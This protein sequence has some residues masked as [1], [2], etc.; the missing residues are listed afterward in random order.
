MAKSRLYERDFRFI[1]NTSNRWRTKIGYRQLKLNYIRYYTLLT[2]YSLF[3]A[4]VTCFT[5]QR[6]KSSLLNR[7]QPCLAAAGMAVSN[8]S[9]ENGLPRRKRWG[10][11]RMTH[12]LE[13]GGFSQTNSCR[14]VSEN[15]QAS[16]EK[17]SPLCLE[18]QYQNCAK[19]MMALP[20]YTITEEKHRG[21]CRYLGKSFTPEKWT[22]LMFFYINSDYFIY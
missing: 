19:P 18:I 15:P 2:A 11:I 1:C 22:S 16:R 14:W 21:R 12:H 13:H 3:Q 5:T 10:K 6:G 20:I 7:G 17:Y 9:H 4:S 8:G